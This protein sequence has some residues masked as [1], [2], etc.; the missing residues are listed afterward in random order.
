[1]ASARKAR[2]YGLLN[3]AITV[4]SSPGAVEISARSAKLL[5]RC[6]A[7]REGSRILRTVATTSLPL[8]GVPSCQ[9][10][11]RRM[12]KVKVSWSGETVQLVASA[13]LSGYSG[14]RVASGSAIDS[15]TLR[16]SIQSIASA[17]RKQGRTNTS[18]RRGR[19]IFPPI[20]PGPAGRS[21]GCWPSR[22][23]TFNSGS[24]RRS[25]EDL[26]FEGQKSRGEASLERARPR[27]LHRELRLDPSRTRG[28]DHDPVGE[29]EG[30][31]RV[32]RDEEHGLPPLLPEPGQRV[33]HPGARLGVE[34]AEGLVEQQDGRIV[35]EHACDLHH[36]GHAC[37][38]FLRI[39]FLERREP[40]QPEQLV[41]DRS[42]R[43]RQQ[44]PGEKAE[45]DVLAHRHPGKDRLLLENVSPLPPG[46]VDRSTRAAHRSLRGAKKPGK[47][48]QQ[49]RL[50]T[51]HRAEDGDELAV[52]DLQAQA[53]QG[54]RGRRAGVRVA[55]V[56][57]LQ[58]RRRQVVRHQA[59]RLIQR[60]T[61]AW[62]R[63]VSVS[64]PNTS[65]PT[66][67][68]PISIVGTRG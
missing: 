37:G 39:R 54:I 60:V 63:S 42:P 8:N 9:S 17:D 33:L 61:R 1:M 67:A 43:R 26:A 5:R 56:E 7:R 31:L 16:S 4:K 65:R 59:V 30:L 6:I 64:K 32:V 3:R 14:C 52:R 38:Q 34:G 22:S 23:R 46:P 62:S 27:N 11:S 10:T 12:W 28:Q 49:R 41:A 48:A 29:I 51:P 35:G 40:D 68:M 2:K 36:L 24:G 66:V 57:G 53:F 25:L 58:Q 45:L 18:M 44:P 13:G 50:S 21:G 47:D 20:I 19:R 55:N 15:S